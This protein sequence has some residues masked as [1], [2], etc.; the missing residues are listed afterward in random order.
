MYVHLHYCMYNNAWTC[1]ME[2]PVAPE[3]SLAAVAR[4]F[5]VLAVAAGRRRYW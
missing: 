4:A 1:N 5:D 2:D 3:A